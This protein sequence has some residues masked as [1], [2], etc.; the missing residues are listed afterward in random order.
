M[1]EKQTKEF[2][3]ISKIRSCDKGFKDLFVTCVALVKA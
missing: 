3:S 1:T 2:K